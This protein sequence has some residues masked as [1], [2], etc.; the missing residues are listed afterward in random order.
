MKIAGIICECNPFHGGHEYL[1]SCARSAGADVVV[2][3]MSGCF[4]QRGDAAIADPMARA[5]ILLLGGADVVLELPFPYAAAGAEFFAAA[6]VSILERLG[7]TELWFGSE[8]GDL[9]RLRFLAEAVDSPA[10]R[11]RYAKTAAGSEGTAKA[12]FSCLQEICGD[13]APCR[14]ND[15]LA[16]SYLRA[17]KDQGAGMRPV[18]V[19]RQGSDYRAE[20]LEAQ[21]FPSATALRRCWLEEG[22]EAVLRYFPAG[23]EAVLTPCVAQGR[24]PA[25]LS[26]AERLILGHLRT[27]SPSAA[28]GIA[29]LSGGLG[30]RLV[31]AA[32]RADSLETLL[33]LAETK[34]YP[35]SRLRRGILFALTGIAREDLHT[36]PAYVRLL[37]LGPRGRSFLS[38][39]RREGEIPV[40]TRR[41]DLP[42]TPEAARQAAWEE[43]A[44]GLYALCMP[45]IHPGDALWRQNPTIRGEES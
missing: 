42:F 2:A 32:H 6:G 17:L 15:I 5:E 24:A 18:T 7:V 41:A 44:Y 21:G 20:A 35:R 4:V 22:L 23:A 12:F 33:S 3:L 27:L 9:P 39:C 43:R 45:R 30:N 10:F 40:V 19:K 1:I 14:S 31:A 34:K 37:A 13:E 29:E 28:E 16:I 8:C 38:R 26:M 11:E 36:R 25:T